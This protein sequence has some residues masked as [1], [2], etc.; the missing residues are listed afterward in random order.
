MASTN[1][2]QNSMT[3]CIRNGMDQNID[4]ETR[5]LSTSLKMKLTK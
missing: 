3:E 5:V 4:Q 2:S 1:Q